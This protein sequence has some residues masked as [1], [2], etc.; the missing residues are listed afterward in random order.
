MPLPDTVSATVDAAIARCAAH[1]GTGGET[2]FVAIDPADTGL[3][4]ACVLELV[5]TQDEA[6]RRL[7][8]ALADAAMELNCAGPV[9]HRIRVFKAETGEQIRKAEQERD[10]LNASHWQTIDAL[11]QERDA[12]RARLTVLGQTP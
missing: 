11:T 2:T 6:L 9:A 4:R 8:Q 7:Q 12:L 3:C 5:A 1:T 10:A